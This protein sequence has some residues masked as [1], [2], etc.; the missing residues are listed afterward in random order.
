MF[1]WLR[2]PNRAESASEAGQGGLPWG[3]PRAWLI[4]AFFALQ[5]GLF[6]ALTTWLVARYHE[7][8]LSLLRS[9][10]LFSL[11]MLVGL[12]S[13]FVLPWLAQR[14]DNRYQLLLVCGL[15]ASV[16][17]GMICF[18]PTLLPEV[19]AAL[20]GLGL[21]GSF[22]LSMVLPLYEVHTPLA[23]SRWTAMMLFAGYGLASLAPILTGLARDLAGDYQT[24][25]MV[26]SGLAL[27][28]SL[29]AWLLGRGRR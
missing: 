26:I 25:F 28:M 10:S 1:L 18:Q 7:A 2:L 3:E 11:F 17:L 9:N 5:A 20:L 24:P 15:I 6:Y 29:L 16:C 4:T 14:F 12:P 19:W 27:V 13:A 8:G 21:S 22:A 23:V